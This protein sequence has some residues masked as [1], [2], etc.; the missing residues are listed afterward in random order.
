MRD[1]VTS[2]DEL[3]AIT[4]PDRT[5]LACPQLYCNRCT[6]IGN[7]VT[8]MKIVDNASSFQGYCLAST[9]VGDE[10][11]RCLVKYYSMEYTGTWILE[12][13]QLSKLDSS[14][15]TKHILPYHWHDKGDCISLSAFVVC[16]D[17]VWCCYCCC[18]GLLVLLLLLSLRFFLLM[19]RLRWWMFG[20]KV[21]HPF[22]MSILKLWNLWNI[23][24][25]AISAKQVWIDRSEFDIASLT[26]DSL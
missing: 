8:G 6:W 9:A 13:R 18:C 24:H 23:H 10:R 3:V 15:R 20:P 14:C 25:F 21:V 19:L 26:D 12:G 7:Q 4:P 5:S 11:K 22:R 2:P 17:T 16:Y 1:S